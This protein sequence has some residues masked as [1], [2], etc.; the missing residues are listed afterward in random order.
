MGILLIAVFVAVIALAVVV[1]IDNHKDQ[2]RA[3][4]LE[5]KWNK[6]RDVC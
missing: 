4:E 2:K 5:D 3:K 6:T 1:L